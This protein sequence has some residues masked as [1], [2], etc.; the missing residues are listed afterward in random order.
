VFIIDPKPVAVYTH[1]KID[2][3]AEGAGRG[4]VILTEKLA[5]LL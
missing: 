2:T 5:A 3:I 1:H 4:V